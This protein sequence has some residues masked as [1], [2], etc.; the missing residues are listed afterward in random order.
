MNCW[1]EFYALGGFSEANNLSKFVSCIR[2]QAANDKVSLSALFFIVA[3][4]LFVLFHE[5][6]RKLSLQAPGPGG[7]PAKAVWMWNDGVGPFATKA[8]LANPAPYLAWTKKHGVNQTWMDI[9]GLFKEDAAINDFCSAAKKQGMTVGFL[10]G[11]PE[12]ALPPYHAWVMANIVEQALDVIKKVGVNHRPTSIQMDV[13]PHLFGPEFWAKPSSKVLLDDLPAKR[14]AAVALGDIVTAAQ[15]TFAPPDPAKP[16][17]SKDKGVLMTGLLALVNMI[18]ARLVDESLALG[19][20]IRLV[21]AVPSWWAGKPALDDGA[22]VAGVPVAVP[23][24]AAKADVAVM[25]YTA[26]LVQAQ[27]LASNWFTA[28]TASGQLAWIGFET[29]ELTGDEKNIT[30][31]GKMTQLEPELDAMT[32]YAKDE[33]AFAT[34]AVHTASGYGGK[35]P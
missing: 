1:E 13:E 28:A 33:P 35:L 2:Q 32:K 16:S 26:T 4:V 25:D 17:W 22:V 34:V 27:K 9:W 19:H 21:V 20:H 3:I 12:Q 18:K 15:L 6:W 29:L 30:Y 23:I 8:V 31:F 14:A 24:L 7:T 10:F 11:A 5:A